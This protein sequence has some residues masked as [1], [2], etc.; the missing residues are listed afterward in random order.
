MMVKNEE[1]NLPRCLNSV[2]DV[3]EE[4]VIVDTGSTDKTIEIAE[5]F[6]A[7]VVLFPWNGIACDPRN[8]SIENATG[9][10]LFMLDAD[11]ELSPE[12]QKE[13]KE[14]LPI[15]D[16]DSEYQTITVLER[17]HH[18]N[19]VSTRMRMPR[20][21]RNRPDYRFVG[22]VH[23]VA[24]YKEK[25]YNTKN[26]MEHYGYKWNT[27]N[28]LMKS[29][30]YM[31]VEA[32]C[33]G[34]RPPLNRL[35]E[36]FTALLL[37]GQ[38]EKFRDKWKILEN[39]S[40]EERVM[41]AFPNHLANCIYYLSAKNDFDLAKKYCEEIVEK[42]PDVTAASF[43][44]VQGS[45][46][47]KEWD[48]VLKYAKTFLKIDPN[49]VSVFTTILPDD[50]TT[51]VKAWLWLAKQEISQSFDSTAT[52]PDEFLKARMIHILL[53]AQE[54]KSTPYTS[55][56]PTI[57]KMFEFV[58]KN[59]NGES[60]TETDL[61][62]F[63]NEI[64]S[65][66]PHLLY[67]MMLAD[68]YQKSGNEDKKWAILSMLLEKHQTADWLVNRI[69]NVSQDTPITLQWFYQNSVHST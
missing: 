65:E 68:C 69:K 39:F 25:F 54:K 16:K 52:I 29:K 11:Q 31:E 3:A 5:S 14:I 43:Y 44:L 20:I 2:K 50:Y 22:E 8:K 9:K 12:L 53:N 26:Y 7:K 18:D 47:R 41:S 35:G 61:D 55:S 36:Y 30:R 46:Y 37:G 6:G 13:L 58:K 62:I 60:V 66:F 56:H 23:E 67:Y 24:D 59:Q 49:A 10:W 57:S 51:L 64:N 34:D 48:L 42:R 21:A 28:A 38:E 40:A 45:V 17:S 15:V 19:G 4:I 1:E 32:L 63:K 27:E 33:Q